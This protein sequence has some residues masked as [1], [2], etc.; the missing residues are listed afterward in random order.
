VRFDLRLEMVARLISSRHAGNS[1]R[2]EH[3][4]NVI[5]LVEH[6]LR[7]E[8][9][10]VVLGFR[11]IEFWFVVLDFAGNGERD[12]GVYRLA[13][14]VHSA[15]SKPRRPALGCDVLKV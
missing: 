14:H 12:V 11:E 1:G 8:F 15:Q 4:K 7:R 10:E 6:L 5:V 2:L 9:R 3:G 13:I